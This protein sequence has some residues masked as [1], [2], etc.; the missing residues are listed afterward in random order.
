VISWIVPP[1][2]ID[3]IHEFTRKEVA[4]GSIEERY[5]KNLLVTII[6][7][8]LCAGSVANFVPAQQP[9]DGRDH[10][11]KDELL[12]NLVGDWKITRKFKTRTAENTAKVEWVLKH[13]F[14]LIKMKD[15]NTPPQYEANIYV[16]Y[17]NASDRYVA[18]WIDVFGGRFSETLG[19]GIRNGN[20]IKFVFEYPDGPFL[21]TLTW[22]AQ[23]K[24]WTFLM[25]HKDAAGKWTLFAEDTLV[26]Q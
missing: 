10:T 3:T 8:V 6:L 26:R 14:L 25:Q 13:Q 19:Y 1:H 20:S 21:N 9:L 23:K 2:G 5:M 12:D 11:F 16:G 17:D 4:V 24:S 7:T 22:N 18:H 15:V